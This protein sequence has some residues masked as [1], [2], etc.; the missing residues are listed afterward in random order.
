MLRSFARLMAIFLAVVL[1]AVSCGSDGADGGD[2]NSSSDGTTSTNDDGSGNDGSAADGSADD[3]STDDGSADDGNAADSSLAPVKIGLIAQD[4]ELLSFPEVRSTAEAMVAYFNAEL[5]GIDGNPVELAVCGAGDAP[6]GH[7]SCAQE[8]INDE[9]VHIVINAGVPNTVASNPILSEGGVAS[10]TL[11]NDFPDYLTPGVFVFD[12]GLLGLAQVFFVFADQ[13]R[14]VETMTLFIADD[15]SLTPFIPVLEAIAAANNIALNE[16]I[17]LG[18]EP[19]LTG[20]I[21]AANTEND[22]W[23]FVL[24]DGAQCTAAASATATAGYEGEKFANDLCLSRDVV[25]SGAVDGWAGPVVSTAPTA[26]GG[27]DVDEVNRILSTYGTDTTT[28][29]LSGWTLGNMQIAREVLIAA[30]GADATNAS[31][32]AALDS[33]SGTGLLGFPDVACPSPSAF[34]GACNDS[35]LMVT[36]V[37]GTMTGPDGYTKLDFTQLEFLLEG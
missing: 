13:N 19:D 11:G 3:G 23:L 31:V 27:A 35:P 15:P 12:P 17:P 22:G 2:G 9:T 25:E 1:V 18:F 26:D 32:V 16:V 10:L 8:L 28:F 14:G 24:A 20:P 4:E 36:V 30:G 5:G 34:A 21:S 7:V 33:Y 29:G 6:E 37:D